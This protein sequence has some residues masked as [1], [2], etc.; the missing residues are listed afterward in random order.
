MIFDDEV[1]PEAWVPEIRYLVFLLVLLHGIVAAVAYGYRKAVCG[2]GSV[3]QCRY[4]IRVV[5]D[6]FAVILRSGSEYDVIEPC[7]FI[8]GRPVNPFS[9][10]V[11]LVEP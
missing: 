7:I 6:A 4:V 1:C 10:E 5:D 2:A 8:V 9:V 11:S 3:Q